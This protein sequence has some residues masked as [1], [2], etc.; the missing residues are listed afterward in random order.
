MAPAV[1]VV[2]VYKRARRKDR[3]LAGFP[4]V[5]CQP[6]DRKVG[7]HFF[8]HTGRIVSNINEYRTLLLEIS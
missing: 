7:L 6:S 2:G 3:L 1:F 4:A 5:S 8:D